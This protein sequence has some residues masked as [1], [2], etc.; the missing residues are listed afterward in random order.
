MKHIRN[1]RK[2]IATGK[3][4]APIRMDMIAMFQCVGI[5]GEKRSIKSR[6]QNNKKYYGLEIEI[7]NYMDCVKRN[8]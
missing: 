5:R 3:N 1:S 2:S 4:V 7:Y 6:K 8:F